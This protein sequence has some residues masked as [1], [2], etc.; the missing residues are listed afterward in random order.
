MPREVARKGSTFRLQRGHDGPPPPFKPHGLRVAVLL[1]GESFR[2]GGFG[3]RGIA[4]SPD[5]Q[6][7]AVE[8]QRMHLLE[9][10]RFSRVDLFLRTRSTSYDSVLREAYSKWL[11]EANCSAPLRLREQEKPWPAQSL[12]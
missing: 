5:A 6:L 12:A 1:L 9:H 2:R 10:P 8:A 7:A 11:V 4:L 3:S